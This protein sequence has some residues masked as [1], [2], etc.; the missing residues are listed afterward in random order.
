MGEDWSTVFIDLYNEGY[1][2]K[3]GG[4]TKLKI[5]I[6]SQEKEEEWNRVSKVQKYIDI[7]SNVSWEVVPIE[8]KCGVIADKKSLLKKIEDVCPS[9]LLL[10][11][12]HECTYG[13]DFQNEEGYLLHK[14]TGLYGLKTT[15]DFTEIL[16]KGKYRLI[17][18]S[19]CVIKGTGTACLDTKK[20][21][22]SAGSEDLKDYKFILLKTINVFRP[23]EGIYL[24]SNT[25]VTR[26]KWSERVEK[27]LGNEIPENGYY[28]I[29][30]FCGTH[31]RPN[32][33]S[34]YSIRYRG[35]IGF[36]F[37]AEGYIFF[38]F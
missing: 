1:K 8:L 38:F 15:G 6:F 31:G 21:R 11:F 29:L 2:L 13:D 5:L 20:R 26:G 30:L 24:L 19:A 10:N 4:V 36:N 3:D 28:K 37:L 7:K 35:N 14:Q 34:G 9:H 16:T 27:L 33:K 22:M 32:G 17:D 18:S 12:S 23:S 25:A